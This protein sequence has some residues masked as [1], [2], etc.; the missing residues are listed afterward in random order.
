MNPEATDGID[1]GIETSGDEPASQRRRIVLSVLAGLAALAGL[2]LPTLVILGGQTSSASFADSEVLSA[3][4]LGAAVL[5]IEVEAG[6]P[7]DADVGARREALFTATNLAPGDRASGQLEMTNAGDLPLRYG[8]AAVSEGGRLDEWLRFEVWAGTGTCTPDQPAPRV[9]E[10]IRVGSEPVELVELVRSDEA[11]V[12]EP[13]ASFLWCIGATL[14]LDTPN[15]AQGQSLDLTLL[16][17]AEHLIEET[18]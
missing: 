1:P 2:A 10:D 17:T 8:L 4:Q 6:T 12:L 9:I 14:P 15:D 18:P 16:V 11:N 3:N 13:G 5:D 7:N